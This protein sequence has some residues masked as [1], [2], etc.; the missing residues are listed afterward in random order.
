MLFRSI[1]GKSNAEDT[2]A[3]LKA[4]QR[5]Y[6][7]N[8]VTLFRPIETAA[9]SIVELSKCTKF[10]SGIDGKATAYVCENYACKAPTT[11]IGEMFELLKT[12]GGKGAP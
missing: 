2:Q 8:K 3:M 1:A 5:N 6:F 12:S 11:D 7:P 4:L 9:L 10:Q